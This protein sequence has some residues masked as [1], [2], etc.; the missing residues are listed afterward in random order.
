[1]PLLQV[2]QF[3]GDIWEP[4][5][6]DGC[7]SDVLPG[8]VHSSDLE[9]RRDDVRQADALSLG[10]VRNLVTNPPYGSLKQLVPYWLD[11]VERKLA[12]LVRLNF[13]EAQSR[14]AW[15]TGAN[16]P[17]HVVVIAGRMKVFGKTSQFPHAWV[18]WDK[19][20]TGS[21][22]LHVIPPS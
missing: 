14:V 1:M 7:M 22:Q 2:V 17:E 19:Q 8:V 21:T 9:P 20:H 6:G 4:C 12:L 18:V 13:L 5:A 16:T 10:P 3:D 15:L 11:T